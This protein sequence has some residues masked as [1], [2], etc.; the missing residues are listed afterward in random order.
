MVNLAIRIAV[1]DIDEAELDRVASQRPLEPPADD[2]RRPVDV[3]LLDDVMTI[4]N[5]SVL[6]IERPERIDTG[7]RRMARSFVDD[8]IGE[9]GYEVVDRPVIDE[10]VIAMDGIDS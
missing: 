2:H 10:L 4:T 7:D 8:V 6:L 1:M 5:W 9:Q 3:G